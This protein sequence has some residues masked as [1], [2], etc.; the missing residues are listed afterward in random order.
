M[1]TAAVT[2]TCVH[3]PHSNRLTL[4]LKTCHS[5]KFARSIYVWRTVLLGTPVSQP[6][7][8]KVLIVSRQM[9]WTLCPGLWLKHNIIC[10]GLWARTPTC[11]FFLSSYIKSV[12]HIRPCPRL[13]REAWWFQRF[14]GI[15]PERG[16]WAY[17]GQ[18]E[19]KIDFMDLARR[20]QC[21]HYYSR[22]AV[23]VLTE[24]HIRLLVPPYIPQC[25]H[26]LSTNF[27]NWVWHWTARW[28]N[29]RTN[30]WV[31]AQNTVSFCLVLLAD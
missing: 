13:I 28:K 6:L 12:S 25:W 10:L 29:W 26:V 27:H 17:W 9:Q 11:S 3:A 4:P 14:T 18:P 1:S 15:T 8:P 20:A 2:A 5:G 16:S 19:K 24:P 23:C 22:L 31:A 30:C 21:T 7:Q